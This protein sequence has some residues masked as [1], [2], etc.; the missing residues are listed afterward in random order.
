M[1]YIHLILHQVLLQCLKL[2]I[3]ATL[4]LRD[5][6]AIRYSKPFILSLNSIFLLTLFIPNHFKPFHHFHH[7]QILIFAFRVSQLLISLN[8]FSYYKLRLFTQ[9]S[10]PSFES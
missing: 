4:L 2:M 1:I 8:S 7:A 3:Q 9:F 6:S 10:L 5:F